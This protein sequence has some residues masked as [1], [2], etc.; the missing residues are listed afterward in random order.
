[1]ADGSAGRTR[2]WGRYILNTGCIQFFGQNL[3]KC[4]TSHFQQIYLSD[5]FSKSARKSCFWHFCILDLYSLE[6]LYFS[7]N[8]W[9]KSNLRLMNLPSKKVPYPIF[10]YLEILKKWGNN[11]LEN[12]AFSNRI[13]ILFSRCWLECFFWEKTFQKLSFPTV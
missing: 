10:F 13:F 3:R 7:F 11:E 4:F 9:V 5:I 1:M 12:F 2:V 6:W 8:I